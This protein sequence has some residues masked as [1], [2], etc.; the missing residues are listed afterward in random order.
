MS[1]LLNR[2]YQSLHPRILRRI[3]TYLYLHLPL[4][5]S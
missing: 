3:S 2:H 1:R 5:A 4:S